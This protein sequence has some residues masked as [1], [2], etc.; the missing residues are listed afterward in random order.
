M[1]K[2]MFVKNIKVCDKHEFL[3]TKNMWKIKKQ[4]SKTS[5]ENE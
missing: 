5:F 3:F 1:F 4:N 2:F